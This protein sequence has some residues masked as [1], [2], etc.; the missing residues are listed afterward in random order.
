MLSGKEALVWD[1][2]EIGNHIKVK[3]HHRESCFFSVIIFKNSS[4][5][6]DGS[7]EGPYSVFI[8]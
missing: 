4:I 3:Y 1:L 2:S 8:R 5:V 6:V 7:D